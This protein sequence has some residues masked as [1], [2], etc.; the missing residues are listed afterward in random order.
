[1]VPTRRKALISSMYA[2]MRMA[3]VNL[4]QR[5]QR[6][7]RRIHPPSHVV[8]P[9]RCTGKNNSWRSERRHPE[10]CKLP[11]NQLS[12]DI[13]L[14]TNAEHTTFSLFIVPDGRYLLFRNVEP[15]HIRSFAGV[16]PT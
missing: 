3:L 10:A 1:M 4:I 11:I 16:S 5:K 15:I 13:F 14:L 2:N 7:V 8:Q 6:Q 9:N 12:R